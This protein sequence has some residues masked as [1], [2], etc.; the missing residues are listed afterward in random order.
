MDLL[1][2]DSF[3]VNVLLTGG[4]DV[5]GVHGGV[6]MLVNSMLKNSISILKLL[7]EHGADVKKAEGGPAP[8]VVAAELGNVE[9]VK[10]LI[11]KGANVNVKGLGGNTALHVATDLKI[12]SMLTEAGADANI[13]NVVA[14]ELGNVEHLPQ[15]CK[16]QFINLLDDGY[17]E[18]WF[19]ISVLGVRNLP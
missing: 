3:Y 12:V 4:A 15:R 11:D 18:E 2:I 16:K 8:I 6:S 9:A 13:Q 10:M 7:V 17:V 14:A 1:N 5:N 19:L